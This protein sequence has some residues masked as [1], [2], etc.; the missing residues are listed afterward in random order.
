MPVI[1]LRMQ[2]RRALGSFEREMD[3]GCAVGETIP[4]P[5]EF[6]STNSQQ[7]DMIPERSFCEKPSPPTIVIPQA[8]VQVQDRVGPGTIGSLAAAA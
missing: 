5:R 7:L 6:A 4:A 1:K 3:L 8:L 2:P